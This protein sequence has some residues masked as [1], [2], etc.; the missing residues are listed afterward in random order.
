[1][2]TGI[3]SPLNYFGGKFYLASWII[4]HFPE[5]K[6]YVEPFGGAAHVL[7]RKDP[8]ASALEVYNDLN[9]DMVNLFRVLQDESKTEKLLFLLKFTP[10]SRKWFCDLRDCKYLPPGIDESLCQAYRTL[11]LMK[12]SF[13]GRCIN[14]KGSWSFDKSSG[15]VGKA[16][17]R[18]PEKLQK[19]IDRIRRVQIDFLDFR[20]VIKRYDSP[21]TFFY[22]DPPYYEKEHYYKGNFSKKDH[23]DLANLLNNI[24]GKACLSYY[25]FPQIR[26]WYP[27]SK[28]RIERRDV[29]KPSHKVEAGG[30][31]ARA[32]ELLIMNY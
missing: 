9:E 23:Q 11:V 24:Q 29:C 5:H 26:E 14:D 4:S 15:R 25:D 16:F 1:M 19:L 17:I 27:E 7:C 8:S 10:H 3:Q 6:I 13:A 31:R 21:D 2:K 20:D 18:M 32:E 12:L 22:C 30:K 28:W